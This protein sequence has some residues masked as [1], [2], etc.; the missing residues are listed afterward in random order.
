MITALGEDGA[1]H[2]GGHLLV[3]LYLVVSR[4]PTFPLGAQERL[5]STLP[6]HICIVFFS[7]RKHWYQ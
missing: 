7:T 3:S 5:Q 2:F 4:F 1:G 6:R